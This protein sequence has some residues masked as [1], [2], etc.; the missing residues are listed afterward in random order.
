MKGN[1]QR[2]VN[3]KYQLIYINMS[4]FY[5]YKTFKSFRKNMPKVLK[6]FIFGRSDKIFPK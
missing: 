6:L 1:Y 2:P 5:S 3:H 4:F